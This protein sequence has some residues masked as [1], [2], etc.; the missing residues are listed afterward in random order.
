MPDN[1]SVIEILD[2]AEDA[3]RRAHVEFRNAYPDADIAD[4]EVFQQIRYLRERVGDLQAEVEN[5]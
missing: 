2:E 4:D 3:L 1:S 5:R